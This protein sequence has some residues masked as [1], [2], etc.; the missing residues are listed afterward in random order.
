MQEDDTAFVSAVD[1]CVVFTSEYQLYGSFIS[2]H[3]TRAIL[4]AS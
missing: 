2:R 1:S 3:M 4:K